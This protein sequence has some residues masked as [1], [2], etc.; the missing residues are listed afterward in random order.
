MRE[1]VWTHSIT[2]AIGN[3]YQRRG[4]SLRSPFPPGFAPSISQT[5]VPSRDG[6]PAPQTRPHMMQTKR[7]HFTSAT[8]RL[9]CYMRQI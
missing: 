4:L 6:R 3:V 2:H 9:H 5:Q 8:R 7:S 1:R